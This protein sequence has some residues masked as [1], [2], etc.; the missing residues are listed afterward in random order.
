MSLCAEIGLRGDWLERR[1]TGLINL[2]RNMQSTDVSAPLRRVA[3]VGGG[4]LGT[5][6]GRALRRVGAVVIG[7][8]GRGAPL[9]QFAP[10]DLV[11]LT[12]PDDA[13]AGVAATIPLGPVVGHCSGA[14]TLDVL[15]GHEAVSMHPLLSITDEGAEFTG[16]A[17]AIAGR[18]VR[19][20]QAATVIADA[21]GME[22]IAVP[23]EMRSLYHAAASAA[24][25]YLVT[26]EDAADQLASPVGLERRHLARLA[27]SALDNW[28]RLGGPAALTGPI[29]RGDEAIVERQRAAVEHAVPQLLPLWDAMADATRAVADRKTPGAR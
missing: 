26:L 5:A 28:T 21:L 20:L 11:L 16:A 2:T 1:A 17:C 15:G 3:I 10:D 7:P 18:T 9:D 25:N 23:D 12:V 22:A 19:A 29:A 6:L 13:I 4:R 27:Q 14:L 24:S 8:I